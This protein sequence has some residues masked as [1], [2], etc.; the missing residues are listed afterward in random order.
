M[1]QNDNAN[2]VLDRFLETP[3]G[4]KLT[5]EV[6]AEKLKRRKET[7][8]ILATSE[9]REMDATAAA[10]ETLANIKATRMKLGDQYNE[11]AQQEREASVA[12]ANLTH[13]FDRQ[14]SIAG[15][16][17]RATADPAIDE[18]VREMDRLF[19]A[20]RGNIAR[21]EGRIPLGFGRSRVTV[22]SNIASVRERCEAIT[23]ARR[24]AEAIKLEAVE[25]VPARLAELRAAIPGNQF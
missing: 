18:F 12:L 2:T 6:A 5:A 15:A 7:A 16:E 10:R 1:S 13:Q 3:Q 24:A 22:E 23:A 19:E 21:H 14:R 25:D 20:T 17:L 9:K 8:K 4:K 11:A